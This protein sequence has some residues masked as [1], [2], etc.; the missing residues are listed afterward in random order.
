M[1]FMRTIAEETSRFAEAVRRTR[2]ADRVPTCPDW[3]ADDLLWHLTGVHAFW[4][5][6]LRDG[7]QT[8]DDVEAVEASKPARPR[9]R[10]EMLALLAAETG[11]LLTELERRP[12]DQ[13][14]WFWLDSQRTVGATRRMQAHEATMHRIDAELTA[15]IEPTPIHPDLAADGVEHAFSTMWAW[16]GTVPGFQFVPTGGVV[17]LVASDLGRTWQV[18]PG[19]WRGVGESGRAYHVAGARL[20]DDHRAAA[21]A[22]VAGTAEQLDRWLWSRGDE[23]ETSGDE[24]A[25]DALRAC[26]A[27]GMQ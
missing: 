6:I 24:V 20:T 7:A 17:E 18:Q 12:D 11:A 23:P 5:R 21:V 13:P 10:E 22:H 3:D 15:G 14:A 19:R 2:P 9:T 25:L 1:T 26:R 4:A 27:E 8:D 16:W